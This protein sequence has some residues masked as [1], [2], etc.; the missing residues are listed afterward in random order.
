MPSKLAKDFRS[1]ADLAAAYERDKDYRIARVLRPGSSTAVLAPHGGGIEAYTADIARGIAADDF[2]LYV[3]EGLLRAGNFAA[4][5]LPSEL[6][7]EPECLDMLGSC[8]RVVSVHGCGL[9][10]ETVL[11]GGRD[12]QLRAA[13]TERLSAAGLACEDAP[14]GLAGTDPRNICNRGRSGRGVQLEV[15][16][17]LRRSSRRATLVRAVREALLG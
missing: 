11:L 15:S 5:R 17:D 8:D 16:M 4:L 1:F 6:F 9:P 2:C 14:V 13:I 10:G 7:D 3:Y 12:E